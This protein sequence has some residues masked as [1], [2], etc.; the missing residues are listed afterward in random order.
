M[1][2]VHPHVQY[3]KRLKRTDKPKGINGAQLAVFTECLLVFLVLSR[4]QELQPW[5]VQ[6]FA[7]KP[8]KKV[9]GTCRILQKPVCPTYLSCVT[10]PWYGIPLPEVKGCILSAIKARAL[11]PCKAQWTTC[12]HL[13]CSLPAQSN[14]SSSKRSTSGQRRNARSPLVFPVPLLH[15]PFSTLTGPFPS[16]FPPLLG[17]FPQCFDGPFPSWKSLAH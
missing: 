13:G 4:S 7:E 8:H 12:Q 6:I 17:H 3:V 14:C 15:E 9:T 2:L 1:R 16:S 5:E 11:C 10:P